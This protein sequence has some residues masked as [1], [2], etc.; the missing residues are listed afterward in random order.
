MAPNQQTHPP[1]VQRVMSLDCYRGFVMLLMMAEVL[2]FGLV[3]LALP[4]S[5]FWK[6][7]YHHQSHAEWAGCSLHDL[8]QP[9]FSFLVGVALPFSLASRLVRGQSRATMT[10]HAAWR[11]VALVLLG[12]F[13]RS[14]GLPQTNWTFEE[15][16]S[17]IGLG[18]FFLFLLGWRAV[19]G[20]WVVFCFAPPV[21]CEFDYEAVGVPDHWPYISSGFAAHW[22]KNSNLAWAFDTWFLNLFPR[23]TTFRFSE[24][25]YSTLSFIPTLATMILGLIVGNVL[26]SRREPGEKFRWFVAAGRIGLAAGTLLDWLGICPIV[27]RLWTPSWVMSSGGWCLLLL[28]GF[29]LVLDVWQRRKW[30]FPLAV[31]GVN[32]IAAYCIAHLV[33][34][35]VDRTL[36]THLGHGVFTSLGAAYE[37]LLHGLGVLL[38]LWLILAWMNR[39]KIF[40]KI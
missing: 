10:W 14:V 23:S 29:Y 37:P 19:R 25:G 13:L 17:Q 28:A 36:A 15:T 21:A 12:V 1:I 7:L 26:R 6:F 40:L 32:S 39:R 20:L 8:I 9:S 27:K 3:S 22:N 4:A 33:A 34:D 11:S 30:A 38:V 31:I 16:L 18:D 35:F 2:H 5:R 24:G